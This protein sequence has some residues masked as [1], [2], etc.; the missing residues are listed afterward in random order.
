[1]NVVLHQTAEEMLQA[2][3]ALA[4]AKRWSEAA[5]V[6]AGAQQPNDYLLDKR[7]WYLSRAKRY[8]EA[9][10]ILAELR[11]R[12]PG[13]FRSWYMTGFQYYQQEKFEESLPWFERALE[14]NPNHLRSLWRK[15]HALE[16]LGRMQEARS[17]AGRLMQL[18][19]E[20]GSAVKARELDA[21][22]KAC[23]LLGKDAIDSD[24]LLARDFL[25]QA[26][27]AAGDDPHRRYQ[28]GKS[29]R[30]TGDVSGA[31]DQLRRART[32]KYNDPYI[33]IEYAS[34][35]VSNGEADPALAVLRKVAA[36]CRGWQAFFAAL[37]ADRLK[38]GHMSV[39]LIERAARDRDTRGHPKV[40]EALSRIRGSNKATAE[41]STFNASRDQSQHGRVDQ[42]NPR[43]GFGFLVGQDGVRRFFK[44][45]PQIPLKRGDEV[46]FNPVQQEKGPAAIVIGSQ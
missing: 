43:R 29:L 38:E 23:F 14:L 17:A 33:E 2:A 16:V 1:M 24:P 11:A 45:L 32:L 31:L 8:E 27:G 19:N 46:V 36:Q 26:V 35:L 21:W 5:D 12:Q 42:I 15:A 13:I 7:V 3:E 28:Y 4:A 40:L 9:L 20:A 34:A 25:E 44:L 30:M 37:V 10:V 41:V 6:L 39:E 22:G 18:Y